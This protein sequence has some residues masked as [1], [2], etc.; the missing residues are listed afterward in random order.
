MALAVYGGRLYQD[1]NPWVP[2]VLKDKVNNNIYEVVLVSG[3]Y[4]GLEASTAELTNPPMF[5]VVTSLH[6]ELFVQDGRLGMVAIDTGDINVGD[7]NGIAHIK[8]GTTIPIK[9]LN[10]I[11]SG[12]ADKIKLTLVDE[13]TWAPVNSEISTVVESEVGLYTANLKIYLKG[14]YLLLVDLPRYG[15][16]S[17]SLRVIDSTIIDLNQRLNFLTDELRAITSDGW[18]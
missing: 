6:W 17:V 4:V 8:V 3:L 12:E 5:D 9:I 16:V 1:G 14:D 11:N 13:K 10:K 15:K 2:F 7:G 18:L